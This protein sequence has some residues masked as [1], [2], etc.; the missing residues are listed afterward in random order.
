M[1]QAYRSVM[2]PA[3]N[4]LQSLPP[5]QRFQ[6]MIYL[7]LMWTCLFCAAAGAWYWYGHLMAVHVLIALGF[8]VTGWTF[9]KA[10]TVATYRDH[11]RT[12]GTARYDD[13]WGG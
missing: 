9:H 10:G 11:P 6:V 8:A 12:D 2:D 7:S 13:V 3:V 4:P 5:A 1:K